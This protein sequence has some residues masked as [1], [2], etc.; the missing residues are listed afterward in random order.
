M[1]CFQNQATKF[2]NDVCCNFQWELTLYLP[3]SSADNLKIANSLDQDQARHLSKLFDTLMEFLKEFFEKVD[4]EN[5][6]QTTAKESEII[7]YVA[8][9]IKHY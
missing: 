1:S 8:K 2:E 3:V 5:N 6:Q 4:F 9:I 7:Q